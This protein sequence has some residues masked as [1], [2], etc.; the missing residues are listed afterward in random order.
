MDIYICVL[1]APYI[2][3]HMVKGKENLT[4]NDQKLKN[5]EGLDHMAGPGII[6]IER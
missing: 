5:I 4:V 2:L 6:K 3:L 1:I